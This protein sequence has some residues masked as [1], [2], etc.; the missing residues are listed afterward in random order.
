MDFV[1]QE[2]K[3]AKKVDKKSKP[4]RSQIG[5][6]HKK[7][8][9]WCFTV[10]NYTDDDTRALSLMVKRVLACNFIIF[11]LEK[12]KNGTP[13]IQGYVQFGLPQ[14]MKSIQNFS[15]MLQDPDSAA[16]TE[17]KPFKRAHLIIANGTCQENINYCSK[18]STRIQGTVAIRDGEP[19]IEV[20]T[21]F[22]PMEGVY[23]TINQAT[24]DFNCAWVEQ[25]ESDPDNRIF[26][27]M[28]ANEIDFYVSSVD[29]DQYLPPTPVFEW[30]DTEDEIVN[31]ID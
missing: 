21:A 31:I 30:S 6:V 4:K 5:G 22:G 18:E 10:N 9:N 1:P 23:R 2:L 24:L 19:R 26:N 17:Y 13:H 20:W 28:E 12:G 15:V 14:E 25:V 27:D 29:L 7:A 11:Q 3:R 8:K 16:M